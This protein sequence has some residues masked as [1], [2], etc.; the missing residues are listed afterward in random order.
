MPERRTTIKRKGFIGI[1]KDMQ[2][3]SYKVIITASNGT[4]FDI[5]QF[6]LGG[7]NLERIATIGLSNFTLTMDNSQGR[8]KDKFKNGN[9]IDFFFDYT[10]GPLTSLKMRGYIDSI[11]DSFTSSQGNILFVDGRD[12]PKSS[13]NEHFADT[14]I[15]LQ[16]NNRNNLD[17]WFGSSG[18][19]DDQGNLQGGILFNSGLILR[20][21]DTSDNTFKNYAD[22]TTEQKNT[23]KAQTGYT[24]THTNTYTDASRLDMSSRVGTEGDYETRIEY[25]SGLDVSYFIVH[26]ENS[27]VNA[28]EH[29]TAGQNLLDMGKYGK[30]TLEEF[31]RV[32]T[33]GGLDG[34][35]LIMRTKQDI[36]RQAA[37][38]IKD[39]I[40]NASI[41]T[42]DTELVE[43][44]N[45]TLNQLKEAIERGGPVTCGLPTL[46][47]GEFI[48]FSVPYVVTSNLKIKSFTINFVPDLIY[49]LNIQ[50]RETTFESIFKDRKTDTENIGISNNPNGMRNAFAFDFTSSTG[51]TLSNCEITNG[52]LKLKSGQPT[53]SC[54]TPLFNADENVGSIEIRAK[55]DQLVAC[56]YRISND[57][58]DT[59]ETILLDTLHTFAS[60]GSRIIVEITLNETIGSASP[61]FK[62]INQLYKQ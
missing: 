44:S 45:A 53:G 6:L 8:F 50:D 18:T 30:N 22:L 26:P 27:R 38:W 55:G 58:G 35:I 41:L 48:H 36:E 24:S 57:N 46:Q 47:P 28:N 11:Y 52:T 56:T 34:N 39:K 43:R 40:D 4:E 25:N 7:S 49:N 3:Y 32:K 15:N 9:T 62:K 54:L 33:I 61:E 17:C 2:K 37:V 21:F 1:P 13:T 23:L 31:N 60:T 51:F 16:F 14:K 20:V 59:F 10:D 12:S 42:T 29:V 19:A 5:S